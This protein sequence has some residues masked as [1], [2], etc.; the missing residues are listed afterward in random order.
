MTDLMEKAV[1]FDIVSFG[2]QIISES[3]YDYLTE[4]SVY[5]VSCDI[6]N[7]TK[8]DLLTA[9]DP[10]QSLVAAKLPAEILSTIEKCIECTDV[11]F[12]DDIESQIK[13][14]EEQSAQKGYSSSYQG[15]TD[16]QIDALFM[17]SKLK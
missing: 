17:R 11:D 15:N 9:I 4:G 14:I 2:W 3:D 5:S 10:S 8:R 7:E 16:S 12:S 13:E 1:Y 6:N